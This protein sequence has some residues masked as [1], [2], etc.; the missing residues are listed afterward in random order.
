MA[1]GDPVAF[2]RAC[3]QC[4]KGYAD[5]PLVLEPHDQSFSLHVSC[6]LTL[7]AAVL[8]IASEQTADTRNELEALIE[9]Y[10]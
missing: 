2:G 10:N 7:A 4:G 3:L 5:N 1:P 8:G 9:R 6:V